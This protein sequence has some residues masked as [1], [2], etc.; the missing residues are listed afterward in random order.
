M[1]ASTNATSCKSIARC[2][3]DVN[4]KLPPSYWDY[5]NLQVEWGS[6]ENYEIIRKVGRGKYSEV[7][8]GINIANNEKCVIK[9]LKPV[10]K[11]KIKREIKILQNLAG[12]VNIVGL[13]DIVRDPISKTPAIIS[14]YVNNTDF[15]ILYPKLTPY[16][17]RYYMYELLKALD[18]CHSKGIMHRDVK[19]HNVM[20]D[21]EKKQLRLIDWGLAEFYHAGT[22]YNVRVAS[23]Y[24]KGPELLVDFQEY[25]YSLDMWSYG[26]MFASMIFRKEPFFHGH[27]NYDQLVKIARVLG[28]DELFKY[29]EKYQIKLDSE[30]DNILGKYSRKPWTKFI[31][32][33]NQPFATEDALDFLDKLL[34][35]DHQERLTAKEAMV[36]HYFDAVRQNQS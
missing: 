9:A 4:S 11:K 31:T 22:A 26:C 35:Y 5:D 2:Y 23:R 13:L 25:D 8:E 15:K 10:K 14:E 6:Q 27:D 33:D 7:F 36:H 29:T 1:S 18:Y 16:D 3:A 24:F 19:P 20:I 28:T 12:G 17:I 32:S 34:R 21:H 30:Y